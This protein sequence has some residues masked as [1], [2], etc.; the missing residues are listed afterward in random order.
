ME[1]LHVQTFTGQKAE[2]QSARGL[3]QYCHLL[4][5]NS[6]NIS[7]GIWDFCCR[8][9]KFSFIYYTLSRGTSNDVLQFHG[10]LRICII[11]H[12]IVSLSIAL[13]K[14]IIM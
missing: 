7:K 10:D 14:N 11:L 4:C 13:R 12:L 2:R 1:L 9:S 5:R 3:L 6:Y 8:M